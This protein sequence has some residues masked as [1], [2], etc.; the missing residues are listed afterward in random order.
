MAAKK[1]TTRDPPLEVIAAAM[2][3]EANAERALANPTL[4][5]YTARIR[6]A[7]VLDALAERIAPAGTP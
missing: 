2:R 3:A 6:M 4:P 7:R 5:G 1:P